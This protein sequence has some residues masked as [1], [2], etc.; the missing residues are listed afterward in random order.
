MANQ[1]N[2]YFL[3]LMHNFLALVFI[4]KHFTLYKFKYKSVNKWF[5]IQFYVK[6]S[7]LIY[8][9]SVFETFFLSSKLYVFT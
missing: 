6:K 4:N 2:V 1:N 9:S 7:N 8:N 5:P 3:A